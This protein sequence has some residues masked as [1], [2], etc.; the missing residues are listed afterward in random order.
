[1]YFFICVS[2]LKSLVEHLPVLA[3]RIMFAPPTDPHRQSS[4]LTAAVAQ[5]KSAPID[6]LQRHKRARTE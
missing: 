5:Q 1:M 2:P 4:S 3:A 6:P